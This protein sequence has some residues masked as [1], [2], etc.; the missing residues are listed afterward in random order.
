MLISSESVGLSNSFWVEA[1]ESVHKVRCTYTIVDHW[2]RE[3]DPAQSA[4]DAIVYLVHQSNLLFWS[5]LSVC[6]RP[7]KPK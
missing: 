3:D 5:K 2:K 1:S 6:Q 7:K 4:S